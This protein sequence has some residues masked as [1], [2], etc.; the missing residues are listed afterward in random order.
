MIISEISDFCKQYRYLQFEKPLGVEVEIPVYK[1][2][3]MDLLKGG[4]TEP[5]TPWV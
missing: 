1:T 4:P 2:L 5:P 3:A